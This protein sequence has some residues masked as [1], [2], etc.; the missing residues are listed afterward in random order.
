MGPGMSRRP[1]YPLDKPAIN[2]TSFL[3]WRAVAIPTLSV[4]TPAVITEL[5]FSLRA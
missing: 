2:D 3:F 5:L 4:R 1:D